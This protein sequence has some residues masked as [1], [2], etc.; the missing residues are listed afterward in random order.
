MI[1]CF[2]RDNEYWHRIGK[3]TRLSM[4]TSTIIKSENRWKN[5]SFGYCA[6]PSIGKFIYKW[7]L[8]MNR[9]QH[10]YLLIGI[11]SNY[12]ITAHSF[13]YRGGKIGF[14]LHN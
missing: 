8:R 11:T 12:T 3:D 14:L 5:S 7:H 10:G 1:L 13:S 9:L 4:D 2:Y 6:I